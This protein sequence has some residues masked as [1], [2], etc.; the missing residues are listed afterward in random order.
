MP[1]G[2]EDS[3]PIEVENGAS[4]SI[5]VKEAILYPFDDHS[6]PFT[7]GLKLQL[8]P[9]K[10]PL[11]HNPIVVRRGGPGDPD[12]VNVRYY[13]TVIQIGDELRMWYLGAGDKLI[14]KGGKLIPMYAVS[15]DGIKWEKPKLGL[16]EY[17]G[18]KQNNIVDLMGGEYGMSEYVVIHEPEDP[19][20]SRRF[21]MV[22]ES[23]KYHNRLAVAFSSDG[24]RWTESPRNPVA[25]ALEESGLVKYNGCYYVNGQGGN[26]YGG[27]RKMVT[28]ASYDFEHWTETTALSFH[29]GPTV[30]AEP[31]RWNNVE[32]VHLGAS[33]INRGNVILGIYGMWHGTPN[34]DRSYAGM[35]LGLIVSN[36]GM[37]FREPIP[38][39]RFLPSYEELEVE[40]ARNA[41]S[42]AQGQGMVNLGDKTLYWYEAWGTGQVRLAT[43]ERDRLGYYSPFVH[44][45]PAGGP[46]VSLVSC[47]MKLARD[48]GRVF[49]NAD[50]LSDNS[51]VRA[52]ILDR[53]FK[54]IPGYTAKDCAPMQ[55]SGFRQA[56]TW[57]GKEKLELFPHPIRIR[58]TF[59]GVR[60]E[61]IKLYAIYV[62]NS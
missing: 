62:T 33:L 37:H 54:P 22:F 44:N 41:P 24:L 4:P 13:G 15:K 30:E 35:D 6:I 50:G 7:S 47:P 51:E 53:E 14:L 31:D 2:G 28:F 61:D 43:W 8:I 20:P 3:L 46:A 29:R 58:V 32:E 16:I 49:I 52:E 23:F 38:D 57:Q 34:S 60:P 26:Q 48:G 11:P 17:N 1:A 27:G 10:K 55:K 25:T 40:G 39:F 12:N 18:S 59:G 42:V 5:R 9:G 56:V 45:P 19:D 21:K 36:D